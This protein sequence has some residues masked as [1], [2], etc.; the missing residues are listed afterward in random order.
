MNLEKYI[1]K[2]YREFNSKLIPGVENV[3]GIRIPVIRNIVKEMSEEEREV[4]LNS[5]PHRWHEEN[6]M[7][8]III[9]EEKDL[10]KAKEMLLNFLPY[11]DNWQVSDVGIP[12]S[13]KSTKDREDLLEFV[14][15]LISKESTYFKR[16][17][18]F[19]LMKLFLDDFYNNEV[20][21]MVA[22]IKSEEYYVNM[23][24]AWLFQ[25]AMV[26]RC[27]DAIKYLEEKKLDRFTHLK[28]ISK[29]VDSRKIDEKTKLYLK[30]LR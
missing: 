8:M 18:V 7:H 19:I 15:I 29:C 16:Y 1:D 12:K 5:L 20:L 9:T 17:G 13:F 4:F 27:D 22:N 11:V 21:D 10:D 28:T 14:K 6:I 3:L 30:S 25:E 23:M 24:R 26:K 2:S